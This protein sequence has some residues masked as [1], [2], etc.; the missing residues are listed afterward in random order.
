M[1]CY[2][3]F[4][5]EPGAAKVRPTFPWT[6]LMNQF[7]DSEWLCYGKEP[8][9]PRA[10]S[11]LLRQRSL[12][13]LPAARTRASSVQW[14]FREGL[15]RAAETGVNMSDSP[16]RL[17]PAECALCG[18]SH[19]GSGRLSAPGAQQRR[20]GCCGSTCSGCLTTEAYRLTALEA[21]S[22]KSRCQQRPFLLRL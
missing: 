8:S 16:H 9:T 11:R 17:L 10:P 1:A 20:H 19:P 21:R 12:S 3:P 5:V 6:Q 14:D 22:P 7:D 13:S 18:T 4:F 2:L 15:P